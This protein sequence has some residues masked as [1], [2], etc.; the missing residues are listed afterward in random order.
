MNEQPDTERIGSG[1]TEVTV[2]PEHG[3]VVLAFPR[4]Q[5][6]VGFDPQNAVEVAKAMIDAAVVCGAK[7]ELVLPRKEITPGQYA[8]LVTR[9]F[10]VMRGQ[11]EKGVN[12]EKI[13]R[14]LVDIVLGAAP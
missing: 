8:T 2:G 10:F 1:E 11:I 9:C 6:W 7:V 14:Q 13:A 5:G 4:P 3:R 12:L